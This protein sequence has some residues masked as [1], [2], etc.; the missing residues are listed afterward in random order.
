VAPPGTT[1]P[2]A[3]TVARVDPTRAEL[4][5]ELSEKVGSAREA[6]W[7]V[8]HVETVAAAKGSWPGAVAPSARALA[9]R[10]AGGEP[11]QY[12][13]GRWPFRELELAVDRRVLIPR[14]ETEQL[15][16][17]AL[18]ELEHLDGRGPARGH[19]TGV[20]FGT[21][22]GAIA[23]SLATEAGDLGP[24]LEVWATD[25]SPEA[26][27]VARTNFAAVSVSN[28][29]RAKVR[30]AR[31]RWF[32]ALPRSLAGSVD[33]VVA[34]PPYVAEEEFDA[35][36]KTVRDFEPAEALVAG[37]GSDGTPGFADVEAIVQGAP[38]WLGARGS[39]VVELAPHQADVAVDVARRSGFEQ[40]SSARDLAGRP[41]F[42]VAR[43]G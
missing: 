9:D 14:P 35:L 36:D 11:L 42:L 27:A 34:N 37:S 3:A 20:D 40:A 29:V 33:L 21:G 22:S 16:E 26:L 15:V 2:A 8:E 12:V 4:L 24:R 30:F 23:L 25:R 38:G 31:G 43:R 28:R 10:R 19:R 17:V 6:Q 1:G 18:A 5:G 7:L 32:E 13:L 39:L 41:R